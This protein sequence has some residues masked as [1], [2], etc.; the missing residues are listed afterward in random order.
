MDL[1][2]YVTPNNSQMRT[3]WESVY[4]FTADQLNS[5]VRMV[6][7]F[8]DKW[9]YLSTSFQNDISRGISLDSANNIERMLSYALDVIEEMLKITRYC[10]QLYC[11]QTVQWIGGYS[12]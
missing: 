8:R 5:Y 11:G 10:G 9:N 4:D 2:G 1:L 7:I 3:D 12:G 6:Q